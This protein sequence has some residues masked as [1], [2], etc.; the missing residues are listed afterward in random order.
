MV[1][2][3]WLAGVDLVGLW[4]GCAWGVALVVGVVL[5]EEGKAATA[6]RR[7]LRQAAWYSGENARRLRGQGVDRG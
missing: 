6:R 3:D 2:N 1:M 5:R 7:A 4:A